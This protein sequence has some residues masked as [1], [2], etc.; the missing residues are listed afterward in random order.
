M[1]IGGAWLPVVGFPDY[2]VSD[3]GLVRSLDRWISF[4]DGRGRTASGQLLKPWKHMGDYQAVSLKGKRFL[5]HT[6]VLE[7]FVEVRPDG[8]VCCHIDGDPS[9][10]QLS[11]LRWGTYSE[12]NTDLVRHGTHFQASKTHCCR[13]HEYTP[14]N[15]RLYQARG[16][17]E[18]VCV[19]CAKQLS[20]EGKA[21][22]RAKSCY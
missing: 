1:K 12:N 4:A 20:R 6:L 5:I 8:L 10:N 22:K 13:G 21:R 15:T 19:T 9:N 18:R 17:N 11:N 14:A 7:A 3:H 2:E 16:F